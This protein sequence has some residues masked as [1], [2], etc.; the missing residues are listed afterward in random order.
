MEGDGDR[1]KEPVKLKVVDD[2]CVAV[3]V[4]DTVAVGNDGV[5][6]SLTDRVNEIVWENRSVVDRVTDGDKDPLLVKVPECV[7]RGLEVTVD[8][9][10]QVGE[11]VRVN[12]SE[13]VMDAGLPV[14]EEI[15]PDGVKDGLAWADG[16]AEAEYEA[17]GR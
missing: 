2:D 9:D 7:A 4:A 3:G 14:M 1:L 17:E 11:R 13:T 5:R 10:V 8:E 15:V 16:V 12:D 6:L